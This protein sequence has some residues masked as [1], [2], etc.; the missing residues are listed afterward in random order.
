MYVPR[1]ERDQMLGP[2]SV[3]RSRGSRIVSDAQG[4]GSTTKTLL[5]D[6]GLISNDRLA[7]SR[8]D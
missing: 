4:D 1:D 3:D 2:K 6:E 7:C 8:V 5:E